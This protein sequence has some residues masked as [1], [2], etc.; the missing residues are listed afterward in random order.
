[1]IIERNA[2]FV[3]IILGLSAGLFSV[4]SVHGEAGIGQVSFASLVYRGTSSLSD[5][6]LIT[7]N[8]ATA[9]SSGGSS[10][11]TTIMAPTVDN[12]SSSPTTNS[13]SVSGMPAPSSTKIASSNS[14]FSGFNG[15]THR[16]QRLAGTGPYNNT[17]FNKEPSDQGLCVGS[18][19]VMEAVNTAL[20]VYNPTG[21]VLKGP[22]AINQFF[23]LNPE[24]IR[25]NPDVYGDFA[26]DPR[27]YHDPNT[28]AWYLVLAEA[29]LNPTASSLGPN[30]HLEIAVSSTKDPT[31]QWNLFSIDT[32]DDG[33]NGTPAHKGCPCFGDFPTIGADANGFFVSTNEFTITNSFLGSF[34][35]SQI[36]AM[37]KT[38]L[39]KGILPTVVHLDLT[40]SLASFK[41][42]PFTVEPAT[43]PPGGSYATDT[44]FLLSNPDM[45]VSANSNPRFAD[46]IALWALSGTS[47]LNGPTPNIILKAAMVGSEVYGLPP[48]AQQKDGPRPLGTVTIPS[49]G[50]KTEKLEL[51]DT[52][53]HF[54]Q[55]VVY[56][57]GE[58]WSSATTVVAFGNTIHSGIA[59]FILAP[60][61]SSG[62]LTGTIVKQ[63]YVALAGED[64]MYP[65]IGVNSAGKGVM[66]F[67]LA[68]PDFFP[69]AAYVSI[70]AVSGA[71]DIHIGASGA[72][73]E[74]GFTGYKFYGGSGVARWGDY[75]AAVAAPNGSIWSSVEYIP[76]LSRVALANWGTFVSNVSP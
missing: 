64:L 26:T 21:T 19:Y 61:S 41:G 31:G 16:D 43:T 23:H 76:N 1:L 13:T 32:T 38:A 3:I 65:S 45:G 24:I 47:T 42:S 30:S 39:A 72:G 55:Q 74:D 33:T 12:A 73:P 40:N 27:C 56:A 36:Y 8:Q 2:L 44:E 6:A 35:G 69:S 59:Y 22:T 10:S 5:T 17:Q 75:S 25:G 9:D 4:T 15:L 58:L 63:G 49:L 29:P 14:G 11:N 57:N 68:G 60:S 34:V 37:S 28:D 50:G 7:T 51:L 67:S 46:R 66:A 70:N 54:M 53:E 20:A 71:G 52:D 48:H 62:S 18:N